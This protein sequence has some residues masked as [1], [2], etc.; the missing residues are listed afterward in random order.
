MMGS[1]LGKNAVGVRKTSFIVKNVTEAR[2]GGG[3]A[4]KRERKGQVAG[5]IKGGTCEGWG[6]GRGGS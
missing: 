6:F 5:D 4:L 2:K 1:G 3:K